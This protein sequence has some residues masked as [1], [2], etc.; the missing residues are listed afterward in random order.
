MAIAT[1]FADIS[2]FLNLKTQN[3][4]VVYTG[5][6]YKRDRQERK[7]TVWK[8][9]ILRIQRTGIELAASGFQS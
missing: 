4:S 6:P 1:W 7:L 2:V 8:R 5:E 9:S 3:L